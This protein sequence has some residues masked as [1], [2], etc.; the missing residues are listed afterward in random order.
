MCAVCNSVVCLGNIIYSSHWKSKFQL[1]CVQVG[2]PA[3]NLDA[4]LCLKV[5]LCMY[6]FPKVLH[7]QFLCL[8]TGRNFGIKLLWDWWHLQGKICS[9]TAS[10]C[11]ALSCCKSK[12]RSLMEAVAWCIHSWTI[13]QQDQAHFQ[14]VWHICLHHTG[15]VH[16]P[17]HICVDARTVL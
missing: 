12:T 9:S 1:W 5:P 8:L 6:T 17:W 15:T 16:A 2:F 3:K 13:N 14:F 11:A 7:L 10:H 4:W